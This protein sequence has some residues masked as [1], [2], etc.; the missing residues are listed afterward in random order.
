[1]IFK[2]WEKQSEIATKKLLL[3]KLIKKI[4]IPESDKELILWAIATV[5]DEKLSAFYESIVHFIEKLELKEIEE[6]E[7][8][9]FVSIDW[10]TYKQAKE[11]KQKINSFNFLLNNL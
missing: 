7:K 1:M 8:N 9:N 3:R 6:I 2:F 11:K 5:S 10:M 4:D